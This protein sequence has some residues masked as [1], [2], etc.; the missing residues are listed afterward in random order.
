MSRPGASSG[1]PG[2]APESVI[3]VAGA[4]M[5]VAVEFMVVGLSPHMARSMGL[6]IETA[7][8]FMTSFALGSAVM[9]PCAAMLTRRLRADHAMVLSLAPFAA[10]LF[11]PLLQEPMAF[12]ALRLAQGAAL[13][14]FISVANESL[15]R[16]QKDDARATARIYLGVT[17]GGL[18]GA[19][20]GVALADRL[21]WQAPFL[22][23]GVL[24][25]AIIAALC[26]LPRLRIAPLRQD[27]VAGQLLAALQ[28]RLLSHLALSL[29][30]FAA[31]F[32]A[33]A[34][35]ASILTEAGHGGGAM[36]YWLLLFGIAGM[37]G[38][39]AAGMMAKRSLGLASVG[40]AA[41][42]VIP[43]LALLAPSLP[44]ASLFLLLTVWG[45]AHAGAFVISQIRVVRAGAAIP[46]LAAT[47]N[48]SAANLGIA[49]GSTLGGWSFAAAGISGIGQTSAALG[50]AA[51]ALALFLSRGSRRALDCA[52]S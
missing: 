1:A 29:V 44:A 23:L 32:A 17:I 39:M 33:Y 21:G 18:L 37:A 15:T 27:S 14:L 4:A 20:L 47:L 5:V 6:S 22:A 40:V 8:W 51:A 43:G 2:G 42:L 41:L 19:P 34:F 35:L 7:A 26:A 28:P 45:A 52:Q 30:Q 16:I 49:L 38:N 25:A 31:M 12:G 48:I 24:A 9:G 10:N 11:V 46:R 50:L 13:P 36:P 3:L